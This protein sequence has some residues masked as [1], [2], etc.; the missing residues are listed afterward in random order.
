MSDVIKFNFSPDHLTVDTLIYMEDHESERS[1][2]M[3]RDLLAMLAF[4]GEGRP[5]D[6]EQAG[7]VIGGMTLTQL[8]ATMDELGAAIKGAGSDA[9]GEASGS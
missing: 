7:A 8:N 2:R 5:M 6:P 4:D 1:V 9:S 3:M